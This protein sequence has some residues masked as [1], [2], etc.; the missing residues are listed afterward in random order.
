MSGETYELR[1]YGVS[2][3]AD[4]EEIETMRKAKERQPGASSPEMFKAV[5]L[6]KQAFPGARIVEIWGKDEI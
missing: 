3:W 1:K 2:L 6:V 4:M 5:A